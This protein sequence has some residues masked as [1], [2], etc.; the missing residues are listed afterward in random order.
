M[1]KKV[2]N[3]SGSNVEPQIKDLPVQFEEVSQPGV[4]ADDKG[5]FGSGAT[6]FTTFYTWRANGTHRAVRFS[7]SRVTAN[8]R[9]FM[10]ISEYSSGPTARFI[11]S[12]RMA[13]YNIA[14]FAGG[15]YA[16]VEISWGSPLN[17]RFD[18]MV[19]P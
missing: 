12:A 1:D 6:A 4:V 3:R 16:W 10:N 17:V 19:D 9:V 11:G 14:P 5:V 8:S 7:N 2:D 15:F 18:V 13:V